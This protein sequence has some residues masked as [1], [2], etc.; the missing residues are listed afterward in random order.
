MTSLDDLLPLVAA[1]AARSA[2][3]PSSPRSA[4]RPATGGRVD[5][6]R[7]RRR[8]ASASCPAAASRARSTSWRRRWSPSGGRCS[9][10]Y[11]VSDDDA[12]AVGLT[13]GGILDVFVERV[14]RGDVPR[15]RRGGRRHRAP[16][17]GRGLH[18]GRAPGPGPASAGGSSYARASRTRRAGLGSERVDDAVTDDARGLLAAGRTETLHLRPGRRAPRRGDAG[19]RVRRT[20][21]SRGCSSSARSTSP[22]PSPGSGRSSATR[23]RSATP[24]RCSPP[25]SRFPGRR[26]GRRRLAAPL[27]RR[28]GGGRP[29]RRPHRAGVL[30]HDPKFDVPLLEVALR[31]PE[32]AYVGAMGSRRTHEDRL[33]PAARGGPDRGRAGPAV[34]ARSGSTSARARRRRPRSA[35][36]PRSSRCAGAATGDRL[37][38]VDGPIHRH[39]ATVR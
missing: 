18:G 26:R 21:P 12:F 39:G 3:R 28:R 2:S 38:A 30:T 25:R 8:G 32:V 35:S 5:A 24:A 10:R 17:A 4:R 33:A 29:D 16:D 34:L 11:G 22:P 20:R 27:P 13:C 14:D 31:L 15:A 7:A 23:S 19:L 1:G 9:Q 6:R 36:P 37:T